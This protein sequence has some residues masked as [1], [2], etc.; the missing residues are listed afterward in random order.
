[1][2]H[3]HLRRFP[4]VVFLIAILWQPAI[5]ENI[6]KKTFKT[7]FKFKSGSDQQQLK[8]LK[9]E[10]GGIIDGPFQGPMAFVIDKND[11]LWVGDTLNNKIKAYDKQGKLRKELNLLSF[12]KKLKLASE[13]ILLDFIP[14]IGGTLLVADVANN[15]VLKIG[16]KDNSAEVYTSSISGSGFW[17]QINKIHCDKEGRVYIEDLPSMRTVVL[18]PNGKPEAEALQGEIGIAVNAKGKTAMVVMDHANPN[19]RHIVVG[20]KAGAPPEKMATLTLEEAIEWSSIIGFD[21]KNNMHIILD[22]KSLR[23]YYSVNP[24]GKILSHKTVMFPDPN[25][26]PN[27]PDWIG[28]DGTIY[29][30]KIEGDLLK[31]MRLE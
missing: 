16:I 4:I 30:V 6:T 13:P 9:T 11:N 22:T 26:D 20:P 23:H 3:M 15:A 29:T 14:G 8:W 21:E 10:T 19:L 17:Q 24:E 27:R 18:K 5:A 2:F 1:M 31:I 7:I 25:Y 12:S 28:A